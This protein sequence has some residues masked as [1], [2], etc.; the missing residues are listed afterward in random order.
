MTWAEIVPAGGQGG[1]EGQGAQ[2]SVADLLQQ[3]LDK[4]VA[5]VSMNS[6]DSSNARALLKSAAKKAQKSLVDEGEQERLD[7]NCEALQDLLTEC[8][9]MGVFA[10]TN[11]VAGELKETTEGDEL[12]EI[13]KAF[14]QALKSLQLAQKFC[15][16]RQV[17]QIVAPSWERVQE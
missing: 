6:Q 16:T 8:E 3:V 4:P 9:I 5:G 13:R 2:A 1:G 17:Q 12:A 15:G 7:T 10:P 11:A 14:G